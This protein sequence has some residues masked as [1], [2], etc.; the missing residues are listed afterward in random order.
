MDGVRDGRSAG[1]H[2]DSDVQVSQLALEPVPGAVPEARALL[3]RL[4]ADGPFADRLHDGEVALSELVTNAVLHGR[5]PIDLC[6]RSTATVLRVEVSDA[7][8]VSPSF[9]W[10]D[11][12]AVTGRGLLLISA[13]SDRWG[14]E[15]LPQGKVVWFEVD[16]A[17]SDADAQAALD[18]EALLA[19]WGDDLAED[20]AL[21]QVRVVLTDLDVG[22]TARS[23]AHVEGLVRELTLAVSAH[24]APAAHL[25]VAANVLR[26]AAALDP[27][28]SDLRRQV[29]VALSRGAARVDVVLSIQRDHAELVRDVAHAVD[30]ADRLSRTG[31]LLMAPAPVELSDARQSYLGRLLAQLWS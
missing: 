18:V 15:P 1:T 22:L 5:E 16:A 29:A 21:E 8:P 11:P 19:A 6:V 30:A 3:R 4:V 25:R 27:V 24:R 28:R 31:R 20:P 7:N 13:M 2:S 14:V 12:T 26:A 17:S 23:E 10:L 9:S